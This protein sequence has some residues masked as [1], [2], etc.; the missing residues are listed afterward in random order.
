MEEKV[1]EMPNFKGVN[2]SPKTIAI[3]IAVGLADEARWKSGIRS[4]TSC[5]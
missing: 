5:S 1:F 3:L 2:V 4:A